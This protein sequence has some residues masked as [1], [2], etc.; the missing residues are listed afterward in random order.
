MKSAQICCH[1]YTQFHFLFCIQSNRILLLLL[2]LL[3]LIIK[4]S[5]CTALLSPEGKNILYPLRYL[6]SF[7]NIPRVHLTRRALFLTMSYHP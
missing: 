2:M 1:N 3:L 7:D 6:R 4:N 5:I